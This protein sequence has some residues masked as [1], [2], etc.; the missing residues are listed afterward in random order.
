MYSFFAFFLVG[1]YQILTLDVLYILITKKDLISLI[2]I[3]NFQYL[4][5]L[6][7]AA[8][9]TG[10]LVQSLSNFR[11]FYYSRNKGSLQIDQHHE[12]RDHAIK[13]FG[14]SLNDVWQ[15]CYFFVLNKSPKLGKEISKFNTMYGMYRGF[16]CA[17]GICVV[18]T[19]YCT[20]Y[21]LLTIGINTYY[22]HPGIA[23]YF[24]II[25]IMMKI[26]I[27]RAERFYK[28]VSDKTL[29]AYYILVND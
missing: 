23:L 18:V 10:H 11:L 26:L 14:T 5:P 29:I 20:V 15:Y 27:L 8:F 12:I 19:I 3:F 17:S 2:D 4:I 25:F 21:F 16:A 9:F 7:I 6:T 22:I 13:F 28:Y 24:G 1:L